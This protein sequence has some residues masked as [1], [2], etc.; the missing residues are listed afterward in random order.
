[1]SVHLPARVKDLSPTARLVHAVLDDAGPLTREEIEERTGAARRTVN[2]ALATL[3]DEGHVAADEHP[4]DRRRLL[5]R[6]ED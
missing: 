5:Y 4:Q 1:M 2:D 6:T 3:R